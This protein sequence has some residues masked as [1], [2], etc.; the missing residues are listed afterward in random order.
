MTKQLPVVVDG[1]VVSATDTADAFLAPK[2]VAEHLGVPL[3]YVSRWQ[4]TRRYGPG[5]AHPYPAFVAE[6]SVV[7]GEQILVLTSAL[8]AWVRGIAAAER[9]G[10]GPRATWAERIDARRIPAPMPRWL[11]ETDDGF[12]IKDRD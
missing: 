9:Q 12:T 4:S 3:E 6:S 11:H 10:M 2:G 8:D 1:R 7:V 5:G